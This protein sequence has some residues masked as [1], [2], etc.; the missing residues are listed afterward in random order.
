MS[1]YR[2]AR[3]AEIDPQTVKRWIDGKSGISSEALPKIF[4]VLELEIRR[5]PRPLTKQEILSALDQLDAGQGN[6]QNLVC[7]LKRP[8]P[9]RLPESI[10][11]RIR[12]Y[13]AIASDDPKEDR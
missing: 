1:P 4:E 12:M 9:R 5:V 11:T 8:L 10:T 13:T 2:L 3:M 6:R 7:Q